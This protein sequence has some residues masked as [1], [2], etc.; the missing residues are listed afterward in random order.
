MWRRPSSW[1]WSWST[2]CWWTTVSAA[3]AMWSMSS[4]CSRAASTSWSST[5][6]ARWWSYCPTAGCRRARHRP[7]RPTRRPRTRWRWPQRR[8]ACGPGPT[9][10]AKRRATPSLLPLSRA[11]PGDPVGR[12]RVGREERLE[13]DVA[14]GEGVDDVGLGLRRVHVHRNLAGA[15]LQFGQRSGQRFAV[16]DQA[17]AAAVGLVFPATGERHLQKRGRDRGEDDRRD[18]GDG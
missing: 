18:E 10:A 6:V 17:G 16:A 3:E 7:G 15:L 2:R 13:V 9:R 12:R 11:Q 4:T 14:P 8:G 5:T 1:S